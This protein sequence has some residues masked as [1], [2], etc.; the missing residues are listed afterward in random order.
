MRSVAFQEV[1]AAIAH[2][3]YVLVGIV[4]RV[5][6]LVVPNLGASRAQLTLVFV[7]CGEQPVRPE[8]RHDLFWLKSA[9]E[10]AHSPAIGSDPLVVA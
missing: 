10:Q 3:H 4:R 9:V 7:N 5:H 2:E 6:I 1:M 8:A